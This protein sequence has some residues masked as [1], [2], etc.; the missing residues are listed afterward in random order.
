[1]AESGSVVRPR[2]FWTKADQSR[3]PEGLIGRVDVVSMSIKCIGQDTKTG[4]RNVGH[5]SSEQIQKPEESSLAA[6]LALGMSLS[7]PLTGNW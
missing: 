2:H 4:T 6:R 5:A 1:M 7:N 3:W